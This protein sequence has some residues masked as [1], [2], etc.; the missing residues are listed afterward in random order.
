MKQVKADG[1]PVYCAHH[2]LRDPATLVEN[3]RNP[4]RHPES[5]L[6]LL[7]RIIKG[8]GWRAPITVSSRSGYI[9]RGHGRLQ[10]ALKLGVSQ[11]P[12]DLQDYAT[13]AE[14]WADLIADNRIAELAE[15][16]YIAMK[17]LL[18]ELDTG[19]FDMDLTGYD[20]TELENMMTAYAGAD[21]ESPEM[22]WD[23]GVLA[24][25]VECADETDQAAVYEQLTADGRT[26]RLLMV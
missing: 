12:V 13:E 24:V 5:Q 10:A 16:D 4:N 14:E 25:V 7:A 18:E 2:E 22:S 1:I 6:D 17:D 3:P 8:Q 26:C 11:V 20:E 23:G 19:E 21:S 15:T 9:V